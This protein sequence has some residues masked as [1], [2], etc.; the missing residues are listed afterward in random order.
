MKYATK[1]GTATGYGL[2]DRRVRVRV[3]VGSNTF[4][5]LHVVKTGFGVHLISYSMGT[6]AFSPGVKRQG[7]KANHSPPTSAEVKKTWNYISTA[8]TPNGVV[9]N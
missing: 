3:P 5:L 4:L 1:I 6:G 2:D 7:S 8:H 9:L